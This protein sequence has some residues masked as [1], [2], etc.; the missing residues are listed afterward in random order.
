MMVLR[1][2]RRVLVFNESANLSI[3]ARASYELT[4][5]QV[6]RYNEQSKSPILKLRIPVLNVPFLAVINF[7]EDG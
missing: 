2:I 1:I 3:W 6:N 5:Y 7:K 4:F